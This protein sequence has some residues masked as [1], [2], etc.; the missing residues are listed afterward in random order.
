MTVSGSRDLKPASKRSV[1]IARALPSIDLARAATDALTEADEIRAMLVAQEAARRIGAAISSDA[2][3]EAQ[4][5]RIAAEM[6][7]HGGEPGPL[8]DR[9][10]DRLGL[11]T[12]DG[13][14]LFV[15]R[16]AL[17]ILGISLASVTGKKVAD[18]FPDLW[19]TLAPQLRKVAS[20]GIVHAGRWFDI[21]GERA[22]AS[23]VLVPVWRGGRVVAML[24]MGADTTE[25]QRR[26]GDDEPPIRL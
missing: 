26:L 10:R 12:P 15:G 8:F 9:S 24:L 22:H 23:F 20:G 25:A 13:T 2:G 16:Q 5:K 18:L 19:P 6:A 14:L 11:F 4:A 21:R 1:D 7:W 3:W 17:D